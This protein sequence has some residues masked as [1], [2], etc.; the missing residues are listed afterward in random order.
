MSRLENE[1]F[2]RKFFAEARPRFVALASRLVG[3]A[4]A[5]VDE[6]SEIYERM[7]PEMA[8]VD[9]PNH[10]MASSVFICNG[11]LSLYLALKPRG[12]SAHD[13]GSALLEAMAS[14]PFPEPKPDGPADT[15][16]VK[17]RFADFIKIAN[18]SLTQ[19]LPGEFVYE[20]V[21]SESGEY[22][23]GMNVKSCAICSAFSKHDAMDLVPYMCATD[24]VVSDRGKQGLR[25]SGTIALGASHCDFRYKRGGEPLHLAPQYPDRIRVAE[26]D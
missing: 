14:A 3:D 22:D 9:E 6:A 21:F 20:T 16:P 10:P 19:A 25:R 12:I 8:Y 15:R 26:E 5:S 7:I 4:E 23:W 11:S 17:E 13:F 24:D 2:V 1:Q 18:D